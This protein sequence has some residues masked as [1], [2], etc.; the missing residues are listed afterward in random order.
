MANDRNAFGQMFA[1]VAHSG[2]NGFVARE[3]QGIMLT[4][5]LAGESE[6]VARS[7]S[8]QDVFCLYAGTGAGKTKAAAFLAGKLLDTNAIKSIAF[9]CPNH[10]ILEKSVHDFRR[11]FDIGLTTKVSS[12][13]RDGIPG[14]SEGYA[15]TYQQLIQEPSLHR[16]VTQ[17]HAPM[18]AIFDEIHHLGDKTGWGDAA[19]EA[20]GPCPRVLA[21]TGTPFRSDNRVIPFVHYEDR[22]DGSLRRFRA[23]HSYNL[24]KCIAHKVCRVPDIVLVTTEVEIRYPF[25]NGTEILSDNDEAMS[26]EDAQQVLAASV[27]PRA[28]TRLAMLEMG[29]RTCKVEGR[30]VVV[31]LGGATKAKTAAIDDARYHITEEL[32][33]L[34]YT[35]AD[36]EVVVG[37]DKEARRKIA[38]FDKSDKWILISIQMVSEGVDIPSLSAMIDLSTITAKQTMVQRLGRI[39]RLRENDPHP[40][41]RAWLIDVPPKRAFAQEV[42]GEFKHEVEVKERR[43]AEA[44]ERDAADRYHRIEARCLGGGDAKL[45]AFMGD[46]HDEKAYQ[47][48]LEYCRSKNFPSP[49]LVA[50]V[51]LMRTKDGHRRTV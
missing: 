13:L 43:D 31:S 22:D 10:S 39:L 2:R 49:E 35:S 18:L 4:E 7:E 27:A 44:R 34:G 5:Y 30:K 28:K 1:R 46:L 20:F 12:V 32:K 36:Y 38:A 48:A 42:V 19:V 24:G 45:H 3:W 40:M 50:L 47:E 26:I 25:D 11:Y 23:D 41:A 17:K 37:K 8:G 9:I 33:A 6:R 16:R 14:F 15:T 21:L 29:L 51:D